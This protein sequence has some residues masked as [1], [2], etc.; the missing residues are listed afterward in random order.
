[1]KTNLSRKVPSFIAISKISVN[2]VE[3]KRLMVVYQ[4]R[5]CERGISGHGCTMCNFS[6]HAD[7]LILEDQIAEQHQI[8]LE[9]LGSGEFIQFDMLT[10]GNIYN[11]REISSGLREYLLRT[12]SE[13]KSVKRV[14]TESRRDYINFDNLSSAKKCLRDDQILTLALGY[15]SS[16][17]FVRNNILNKGVEEAHLDEALDMCR[18]AFIDF[19]AYILIKPP[20]LTEAESIDD[21]VNTSVHVL[22]KAAKYGVNSMVA[23]QP[24]FVTEGNIMEKLYLKGKYSPP[25]LWSVVEI[26]IRSAKRLGLKDT[27]GKFFVGLSDE[28]LSHGRMTGNNCSCDLEILNAIRSFNGDQQISNLETLNHHCKDLW[29]SE[30]HGPT[31]KHMPWVQNVYGELSYSTI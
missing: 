31:T 14:I 3:G 21:A 1:M 11:E 6:Y 15:E 7:P 4:T 30:M 18:S 22:K 20:F 25:K 27:G 12:V 5:G 26:L 29:L 17:E 9:L 10:L 8:A 2:G 13:V 28:N 24:A 16:C 19:M 23:F